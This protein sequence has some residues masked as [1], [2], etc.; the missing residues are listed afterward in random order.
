[1]DTNY[2]ICVLQVIGF[3]MHNFDISV[4]KR[5]SK[6]RREYY[7]KG[8]W[9]NYREVVKERFKETSAKGDWIHDTV[10]KMLEIDEVA[11]EREI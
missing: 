3:S 7:Q 1:M 8:Y 9:H 10:L 2:C 5:K 11:F 4:R 6:M